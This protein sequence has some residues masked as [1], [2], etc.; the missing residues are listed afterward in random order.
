MAFSC[1][2]FFFRSD[3]SR[4]VSWKNIHKR[5]RFLRGPRIFAINWSD[6][7]FAALCTNNCHQET[8]EVSGGE[9]DFHSEC[10]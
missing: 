8:G 6:R 7:A 9:A 4:L 10:T 5:K 2:S 3:P 1:F